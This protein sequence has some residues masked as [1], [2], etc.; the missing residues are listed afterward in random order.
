MIYIYF[1]PFNF[2]SA[3]LLAET[4]WTWEENLTQITKE[5]DVYIAKRKKE[6]MEKMVT[7]LEK[8]IQTGLAEP[9]LV[10]LNECKDSM[11]SDVFSTFK[12]V[13]SKAETEFRQRS[14]GFRASEE[15]VETSIKDLKRQ[16]WSILRTR[17]GEDVSDGLMSLRLKNR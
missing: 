12:E 4:N 7:S 11:W 1:I 3:A 2:L 14:V 16:A 6:V 5:I 10:H 17:I 8:N 13:L 15:E 9:V